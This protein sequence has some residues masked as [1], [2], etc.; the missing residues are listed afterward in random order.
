MTKKA[1]HG[2][3]PQRAKETKKK[4]VCP[5][6]AE[7]ASPQS[8][9]WYRDIIENLN[10]VVYATDQH[11]I[12]TYISPVIESLAGYSPSEIIGRSYTD[13]IHPE[14]LSRIRSQLEKVMAGRGEP[15]EYRILTKLGEIRWIRAS[16]RPRFVGGEAI[17]L[18]G[19]FADVT[20][21]KVGDEALQHEFEMSNKERT[22]ELLKLNEELRAEIAERKNAEKAMRQ[23]AQRLQIAYDQA[24]IYGK[25]LREEMIQ[26]KQVEQALIE[27]EKRYKELWDEAPIAYHV[28]D[29]TGI[30]TQVNKTETAMLGYTREEMEGKSIFDFI[31]PEQRREARRRF[32]LKLAGKNIPK[33]ENR[34]YL[35]K[36]GSQVN[37]SIDDA[38]ERAES[39]QV[40]GVRTTMVDITK[41]K[42]TELELQQRTQELKSYAASLEEMNVALKVLLNKRAEDKI[43]LGKKVVSNVTDLVLPYLETLRNSQLDA[44]QKGFILIIESNLEDILSPFLQG[45]YSKFLRLTPKEVQIADLIRQ[46]NTTKEIAAMFHMSTRAV[47]FHRENIRAK[48]DLK[49]KPVNLRSYLMSLSRETS[50]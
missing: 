1:T 25:Q 33:D 5:E 50:T 29:T 43:E 42:M 48:L 45:L 36:N 37:V 38:L 41:S 4:M 9:G 24:R 13:F 22:S 18:C 32:Q 31:L 10:D 19:V 46:G 44:R 49:N 12:I 6:Q 11:G 23:N 21:R 2:R 28:L 14:D 47:R 20:A 35:R 16:S 34:T 7:E 27:N 8:D 40:T 39:G 3:A 30:V 15:S 17:G 26:R